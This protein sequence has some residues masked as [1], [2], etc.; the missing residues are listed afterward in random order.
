MIK[1][2]LFDYDGTLSNRRRAAYDMYKDC[3][4]QMKPELDPDGIE[5]ESIVQ[6]CMVSDQNGLVNKKYV[7]EMLKNKYIPDLDVALWTDYWYQN[8]NNFQQP[9]KDAEEVLGE[10]RK[11]YKTGILSN[12]A[13]ESQLAKIK[14]LNMDA[15]VDEVTISGYYGIPKPDPRIFEIAAEKLGVTCEETA[16]VGDVFFTDILG[17]SK[18]GMKPVWFVPDESFVSDIDITIVRNFREIY[19][20]FMEGGEV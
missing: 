11:K 13:Y 15:L 1:A 4:M 17:A 8:F 16:F 3:I 19:T 18:A 5:L 9:Q 7:W 10:L 20:L 14:S 6:H 2:I 12:G